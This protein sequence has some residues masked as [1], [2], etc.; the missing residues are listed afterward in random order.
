MLTKN[1]PI[2]S[3]H[4]YAK[5]RQS[6]A[7]DRQSASDTSFGVRHQSQSQIE[8]QRQRQLHYVLAILRLGSAALCSIV[9]PAW[10]AWGEKFSCSYLANRLTPFEWMLPATRN[11]FHRAANAAAVAAAAAAISSICAGK[12]LFPF[13]FFPFFIHIFLLFGLVYNQMQWHD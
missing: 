10:S 12:K 1:C 3:S 2:N 5:N 13:L 11:L 4:L 7:F 9:S 8:R 6:L